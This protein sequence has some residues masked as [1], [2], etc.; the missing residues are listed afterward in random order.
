[1]PQARIRLMEQNMAGHFSW[2]QR[3]TKGMAVH[4]QEGWLLVNSGLTCD[5]FNVLFYWGEPPDAGLQ[6]A[7]SSFRSV[8]L[9][10]AVWLGPESQDARLLEGLGLRLTEVETGMLLDPAD[11]R[12]G[13]SVAGLTV[14][15]VTDP[16][17]LAHFAGVIAGQPPDAAVV[18][19]YERGGP[20]I[21][22]PDSPM[23]LFLGC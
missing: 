6:D 13:D 9:P 16:L 10:F 23:R 4:G 3:A 5:S 14:E 19:F 7:I 18:R 8:A 1:M 12:H 17:R 15:R 11:Y 20:A 2:L 21:L 22:C